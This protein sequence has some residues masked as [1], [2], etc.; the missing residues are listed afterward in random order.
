MSLLLRPPTWTTSALCIGEPDY[1]H[2]DSSWP[3]AKAIC[4][5]CP[6]LAECR[7][8]GMAGLPLGVVEGVYGGLT[9]GELTML[10][11]GLG[12]PARRVAQ[13]GTRSR[14]VAGACLPDGSRCLPCVE[15]HRIY[16]AERRLRHR[17][18]LVLPRRGLVLTMPCGRGRKRAWPGQMLLFDQR[19][20]A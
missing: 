12:L 1:W 2:D 8:W 18:G 14:Y 11:R 19:R 16:E 9:P 6:V 13:H 20:S 3:T 7:S 4:E 15:A 10:A 5:G 17:L